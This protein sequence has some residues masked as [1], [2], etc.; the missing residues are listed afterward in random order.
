[1][2]VP[3]RSGP[4]VGSAAGGRAAVPAWSGARRRRRTA[5]GAA[6]R[7][8]VVRRSSVNESPQLPQVSIRRR[9]G[10]AALGAGDEER[11]AASE[12]VAPGS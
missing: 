8:A 7:S 2:A 1:M 5:A 10:R 3:G 6:G 12:R 9:V 4:A 11:L